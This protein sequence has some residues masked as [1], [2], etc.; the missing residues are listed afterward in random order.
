M[1]ELI[2]QNFDQFIDRRSIENLN[3]WKWY[4]E[5]V[6]PMW[7]ADMDFPTPKPIV[8]SIRRVL[9]HG[10]LG[11]ERASSSLFEQI[12]GRL[13]RLHGW[14]IPPD[15]IIPVPSVSVGYQ[16]A[17][18]I[19]CKPGEGVLVQPPVYHHFVDFPQAYHLTRQDAPLRRVQKRGFLGYELDAD[20]LTRAFHSGAKTS[21][22]LLC[23]PH[24][25]VG[26]IYSG[27]ELDWMAGVCADNDVI[28]CSD[29][30]HHELLL[31][32]ARYTPIASRS[33]QIAERT[34]TLIGPGKAFNVSGLGCA[35]AIIAQP[36]L[37]QRFSHEIERL[38]LE[39]NSLGLAAARAAYS[40]ECDSWLAALCGYLATNRDH[41]VAF[42]ENELPRLKTT[43]PEATYLA[44]LDCSAY[45]QAGEIT[46]SPHEFLLEHAKVALSDGVTF[47]PG[48]EGFVRLSFACP[49]SVLEEG[50]KRIWTALSRHPAAACSYG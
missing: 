1:P 10:I 9:D 30:I 23:N 48:G 4:P 17:A 27:E 18:S 44:W 32:E 36:D 8:D 21:M 38:G 24:N 7:L 47:G 16:V 2:P 50:L 37:R 45:V 14:K 29:D 40:G 5:D 19:T 13:D 39:V 22:F 42:I 35:F 26:K 49:R 6:L 3:K 20:A 34:I 11:Y 41:L 46:G 31:G 28:I 43:A 25:P 33:P 12:A 15:S